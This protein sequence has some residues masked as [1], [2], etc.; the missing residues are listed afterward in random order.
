MSRELINKPFSNSHANQ[1]LASLC[2]AGLIY[3]NR[4]GRYLFA[5]PLLGEF[6]KRQIAQGGIQLPLP[7]S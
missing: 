1:L 3:K 2:G 6:I 4:H 7:S 5:V